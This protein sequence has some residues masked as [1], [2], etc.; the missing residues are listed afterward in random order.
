MGGSEHG[1]GENGGGH[2]LHVIKVEEINLK[3]KTH[4]KAVDL[5]CLF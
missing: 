5:R 2:T 3:K 4:P 1:R